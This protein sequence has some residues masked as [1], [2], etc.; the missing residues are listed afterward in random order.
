MKQV[1]I[2]TVYRLTFEDQ[3]WL[4]LAQSEIIQLEFKRFLTIDSKGMPENDLANHDFS[5]V[6]FHRNINFG[7]IPIQGQCCFLI[8]KIRLIMVDWLMMLGWKRE[9]QN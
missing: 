9:I 4:V 1:V 2:E 3:F 7:S 6:L 8:Q 5:Q